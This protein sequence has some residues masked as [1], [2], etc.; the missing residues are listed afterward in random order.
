MTTLMTR[1]DI[2]VAAGG[3]VI[4]ARRQLFTRVR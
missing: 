3:K 1:P 2:P 4:V